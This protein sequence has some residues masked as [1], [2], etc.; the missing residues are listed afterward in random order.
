M[1]PPQMHP[2]VAKHGNNPLSIHS[3]SNIRNNLEITRLS[4]VESLVVC[5]YQTHPEFLVHVCHHN[6]NVFSE[7]YS[8]ASQPTTIIV[9]LWCVGSDNGSS[10][11]DGG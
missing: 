9:V 8:S 11:D 10:D 2:L 6:K 7:R 1:I 3:H 5:P 4:L